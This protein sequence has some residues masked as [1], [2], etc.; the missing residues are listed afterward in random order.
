MGNRASDTDEHVSDITLD[1]V[2]VVASHRS[3]LAVLFAP[4]FGSLVPG[5]CI[6]RNFYLEVRLRMIYK[7][8]VELRYAFSQDS[9]V[10][11]L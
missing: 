8:D 1:H 6:R 10:V 7:L 2:H 5:A 9:H 11:Q 4:V 3:N